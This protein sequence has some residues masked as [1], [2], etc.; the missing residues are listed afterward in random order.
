MSL[1]NGKN[2][3]KPREGFEP[4]AFCFMD[5]RLYTMQTLYH[6]ELPRQRKYTIHFLLQTYK[7]YTFAMNEYVARIKELKSKKKLGQNF[8]V[9]G[10]IAESESEYAK[11]RAVVELGPGLGI[12]T[13]ELCK[14]AKSVVSIEKDKRL[15]EILGNE[16]NCKNTKLINGDFFKQPDKVFKGCEIM[17]SNI[18]YNMSS[19]TIAWL[20]RMHMEAL[21]C[22]QKEFAEH[23]LAEPGTKRYSKLSVITSLSFN[24]YN[25]MKVPRNNFYPVPKVDSV[26]L[27]LKPKAIAI[28]EE[29]LNVITLIME[30]KK[31]LLRNAISDS[32]SFLGKDYMYA[33][34]AVESMGER[35]SRVFELSPTQLASVSEK[36]A[37][38]IKE[39]G[40]VQ[41]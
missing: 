10:S 20:Q 8:L 33:I 41:S 5:H 27:Y 35:D 6:A 24:A 28:S 3:N 31:K 36:V 1:P 15:F 2:Y 7:I 37:I 17:V 16:L 11:G 21:L 40:K 38:A 29:A 25:M 4:S 32:K 39:G 23:M 30:H 14:R 34:S 22:V 26:I 18:P 19:K 13:T 9:N 12:L